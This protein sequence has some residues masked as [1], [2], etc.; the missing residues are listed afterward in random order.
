MSVEARALAAFWKWGSRSVGGWLLQREAV[1]PPR[2]QLR[3]RTIQR[4]G[5]HACADPM[6]EASGNQGESSVSLEDVCLRFTADE[7][8]LLDDAQKL[9]YHNV[10]L[11]NFSLVLSLG[12]PISKSCPGISE[13]G[14]E[15]L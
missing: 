15:S 2:E 14:T 11:E 3:L 1:R 8:G 4:L 5:L 7:W 13:E 9:L 12:L 6:A 10:M